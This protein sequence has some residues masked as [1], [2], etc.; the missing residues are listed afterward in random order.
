MCLIEC[1]GGETPLWKESVFFGRNIIETMEDK[2]KFK[3][4]IKLEEYYKTA[5]KILFI[6][7]NFPSNIF[8]QI[9]LPN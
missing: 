6:F 4:E 2:K 3:L 5:R 7:Q 1:L 8:F 9:F